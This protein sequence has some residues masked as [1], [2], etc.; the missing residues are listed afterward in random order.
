MGLAIYSLIIL[1]LNYI[2]SD[3]S[4]ELPKFVVDS[5]FI[6]TLHPVPSASVERIISLFILLTYC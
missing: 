5:G 2:K 1:G 6:I 3:G 4:V